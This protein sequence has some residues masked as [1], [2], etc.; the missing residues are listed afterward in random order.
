MPERLR[1][2]PRA[3]GGGL[4][5]RPV[6]AWLGEASCW[7]R[8][9][10]TLDRPPRPAGY[11]A[12]RWGSVPLAVRHKRCTTVPRQNW[13]ADTGGRYGSWRL[14]GAPHPLVPTAAGGG[15]PAA[16]GGGGIRHSRGG[17]H[18]GPQKTIAPPVHGGNEP[19]RLRRIAQ[20]SAQ[21]AN[22]DAH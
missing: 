11:P 8:P 2:A 3:H 10:H 22:G 21:L 7:A 9:S 15:L 5:A 20:H 13:G 6:A 19:G 16:H 1:G 17:R 14:A 18:E 4:R 12:R